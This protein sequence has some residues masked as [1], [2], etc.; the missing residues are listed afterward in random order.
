MDTVLEQV[1]NFVGIII[2]P[3]TIILWIIGSR[4]K[5]LDEKIIELEDK[6][7]KLENQKDQTYESI[8]RFR[9]IK[10]VG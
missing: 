5:D 4:F 2:L 6:I 10:K 7:S 3:L 1:I 9:T 8:Y